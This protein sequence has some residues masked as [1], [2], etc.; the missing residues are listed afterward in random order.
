MIRDIIDNDGNIIG[1]IEIEGSEADIQENLD[2]YKYTL[3]VIDPLVQAKNNFNAK[4]L[5][6]LIHTDWIIRRHLDQKLAS[7]KTTLTESNY[8]SWLTYR[9]AIRDLDNNVIDYTT[10][11]FPNDPGKIANNG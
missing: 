8:Q 7:I 5:D 2:L 10:I 4:Q 9:Q 11:I 6:I 3:P 1:T